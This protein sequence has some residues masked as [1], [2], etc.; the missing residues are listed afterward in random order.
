MFGVRKFF[1]CSSSFNLLTIHD[2]DPL[3]LILLPLLFQNKFVD[4]E[5]DMFRLEGCL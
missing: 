4:Q 2:F 3:I 1:S 5:V